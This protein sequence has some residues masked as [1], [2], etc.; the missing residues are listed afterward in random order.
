MEAEKHAQ[1][2]EL[3]LCGVAG[4]GKPDHFL[5]PDPVRPVLSRRECGILGTD[6][7]AGT[8][9]LADPVTACGT[10]RARQV[11]PACDKT[12]EK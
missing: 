9:G 10:A 1:R 7:D 12:P 3:P 5:S 11:S 4:R 6:S 8:G 2:G